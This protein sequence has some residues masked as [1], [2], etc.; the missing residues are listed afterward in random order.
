MLR[1]AVEE[2]DQIMDALSQYVLTKKWDPE[3]IVEY[4]KILD[5][6]QA[7]WEELR[8]K[9]KELTRTLYEAANADVGTY[10]VPKLN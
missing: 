3:K 4:E 5:D 8:E 1:L 7:K 9:R 10:E 2:G 6:R